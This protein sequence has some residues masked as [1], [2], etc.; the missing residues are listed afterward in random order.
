MINQSFDRNG[1]ERQI[2]LDEDDVMKLSPVAATCHAQSIKYWSFQ[3]LFGNK[4]SYN[5]LRVLGC[6][7]LPEL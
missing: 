3:S 4:S 2:I 7:S 6:I 5:Y 1:S